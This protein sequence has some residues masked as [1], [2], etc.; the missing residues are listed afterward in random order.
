LKI[1]TYVLQ[2]GPFNAEEAAIFESDPL[3]EEKVL[4]RK[5]DDRAKVVGLKVPR[6]SEYRAIATKH[7]ASAAGTSV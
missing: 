2:G 7:L 4:M 3:F 5:F 1:L 6:I